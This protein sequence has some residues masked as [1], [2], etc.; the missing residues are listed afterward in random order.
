MWVSPLKKPKLLKAEAKELECFKPLKLTLPRSEAKKILA[1]S[2][3]L[4]VSQILWTQMWLEQRIRERSLPPQLSKEDAFAQIA[5]FLCPQ[6]ALRLLEDVRSDFLRTQPPLPS[7]QKED[8]GFLDCLEC[9]AYH[10]HLPPPHTSSHNNH[11][12]DDDP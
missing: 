5:S 9:E 6:D 3:N 12:Q 2:G 11:S 8:L 10:A 1:H 7:E 4:S